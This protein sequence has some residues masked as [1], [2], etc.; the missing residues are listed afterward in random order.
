M[1]LRLL[2]LFTIIIF[3]N[4]LLAAANGEELFKQCKACHTLT[5]D[6]LVGPGLEGVTEKRDRKWLKSWITSSTKFRETDA[7]AQALFDEYKVPMQDFNFTDEEL[8]ALIDYLGGK[9]EKAEDKT[10]ESAHSGYTPEDL[11]KAKELFK[12]CKACHS[13]G[14]DKL[15]GPGLEG[16]TKK[17]SKEWLKSWITSSTKFRETDA[18]AQALFDEYKI[19]MQDFN[20]SDKDLDLLIAYLGGDIKV[21][22]KATVADTKTETETN[23]TTDEVK[24]KDAKKDSESEFMKAFKNRTLTQFLVGLTLILLVGVLIAMIKLFM[25]KK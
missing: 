20:L 1:K 3:A 7:D 24:D 2:S 19:P 17:R 10:A 16:V 14:T 25:T 21:E 13:L 23:T 5:A 12:Q 18:D 8:D 11:S 4:S 6:R 15:V 9:S 22:E